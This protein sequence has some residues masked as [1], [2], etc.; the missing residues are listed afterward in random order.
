MICAGCLPRYRLVP[1]F[2]VILMLS[3]V[4]LLTACTAPTRAKVVSLEQP[5]YK[6]VGRPSRYTVKRKDTLY[7]IAWNYGL[8]F[9]TLARWNAIAPPYTIY[10]GQTLVLAGPRLAPRN[11]Q[12]SGTKVP[13][14]PPQPKP[15]R[16][17][18]SAPASNHKSPGNA[19]KA[20]RAVPDLSEST[21]KL[22]W[23]WPTQGQLKQRYSGTDPSRKG[24]KIGGT[25]GQPVL[26]AES[27]KVVYAGSGL[28][29]YGLLLI[30]RHNK[31]YLSAYGH[32]RKL[33][34]N[35]GALVKKG[36]QV[37]EMGQ[38]G[39]GS[40]VLHFEIRRNGTPVDPL[41]LLPRQP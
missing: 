37:A 1:Y 13:A 7:T 36:M 30:I 26:A 27:G 38:Q 29:G 24:I 41:K 14:P 2:A 3:G 20:S 22:Y 34:V 33:L 25:Q 28:I 18:Q 23:R 5:A 35:E 17:A 40:P 32:N 4:Q 8:D 9:R 10:P 16:S 12:P 19:D 15:I 39:G 31:N 6:T 11:P 21:R